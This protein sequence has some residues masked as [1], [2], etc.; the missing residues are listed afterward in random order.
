MVHRD[1]EQAQRHILEPLSTKWVQEAAGVSRDTVAAWRRGRKPRADQWD[2]FIATFDAWRSGIADTTKEPPPEWA[3]VD[4]LDRI[5]GLLRAVAIRAGVPMQEIEEMHQRVLE[6]EQARPQP[7]A[8][9]R[10]EGAP[11]RDG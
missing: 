5:E 9:D 11:A 2:R 7:D 4:Q 1:F 3:G 8:L 10:S 6:L